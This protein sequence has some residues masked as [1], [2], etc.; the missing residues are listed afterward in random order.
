MI[1]IF[2]TCKG[3]DAVICICEHPWLKWYACI[4]VDYYSANSANYCDAEKGTCQ[5][6]MNDGTC[7][8]AEIC[9]KDGTCKGNH[10]EMIKMHIVIIL[11]TL[12]LCLLLI[13]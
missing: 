4:S 9:S 11:Y 1:F 2:V 12:T 7:T 5:C 3:K 13:L 6:T 10:N 8:G